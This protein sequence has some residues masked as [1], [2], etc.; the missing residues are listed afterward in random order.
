M[1]QHFIG[2]QKRIFNTFIFGFIA[3]ICTLKYNVIILSWEYFH[4]VQA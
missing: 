2:L 3:V 1:V 4:N